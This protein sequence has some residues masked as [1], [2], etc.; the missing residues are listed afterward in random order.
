MRWWTVFGIVALSVALVQFGK[1]SAAQ[2]AE[3]GFRSPFQ[4]QRL[5]RMACDGNACVES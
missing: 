5:D 4:R 2:K 1:M 3:E